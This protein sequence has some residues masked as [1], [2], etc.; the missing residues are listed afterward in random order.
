MRGA[1][2]L[3]NAKRG[4]RETRDHRCIGRA[5]TFTMTF[6]A[7][8]NVPFWTW[9][10]KKEGGKEKKISCIILSEDSRLS[11]FQ[12]KDELACCI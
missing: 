1:A 2:G 3:G 5:M 9:G 10:W 4:I 7:D 12:C 6:R 11:H 8:S